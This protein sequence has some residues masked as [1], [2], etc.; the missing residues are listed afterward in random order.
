MPEHRLKKVTQTDLS[1]SLISP[2]KT[3]AAAVMPYVQ[4]ARIDHWFKNVFMLLGV[5]LALFYD[6]SSLELSQIPILIV[7]LLVT[8]VVASSNYVINEFLDGP[9]DRLHPTK[10]TRPAAQGLVELR[11]VLVEWLSLAAIGIF[12]AF[13]IN[14]VFG[15]AALVFWMM[16]CL[17]NIRPIRLKDIPYLDVVSEAFNNPLRLLMGWSLLIP[18]RMPPVSLVFSFW[19]AAA[20]F[21]ATKRFAEYRKINDPELAGLYRSSFRH[22]DAEKLLISMMYYVTFGALFIGIFIVRYKLEL[23]LCVPFVAGF[24]AY[25][26]RLALEEDSPVQAPEKLYKNRGFLYYSI[27]CAVIF[28]I[29]MLIEIPV[30]YDF[31]NVEAARLE[32]LWRLHS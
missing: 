19:F 26:L 27:F 18:D 14:I 1:E 11:F 20:F 9:L 17:Y 13:Q 16:G 8:C 6:P 25:Y 21:M 15:F 23:I 22:Y 24:F 31:F 5:L 4:I 28:V 12:V 29:T 32:P 7:G 2:D 10:K 30:L 3:F